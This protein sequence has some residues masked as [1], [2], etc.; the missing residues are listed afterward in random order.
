M[1]SSLRLIALGAGVLGAS[2]CSTLTEPPSPRDRQKVSIATVELPAPGTARMPGREDGWELV[3]SDEFDGTGIDRSKWNF[4]VDCWGGGNDERQCYTDRTENARVADG[5]LIITARKEDYTGPAWPPHMRNG[6]RDPD[7][8]VTKPYTSARL[9][10]RGNAAWT[11]GRIEVRARL[12]QGQG[13]WPAI[14][15]LPEDEDYGTWAASGEIDILEVVN[16][17]IPCAECPSGRE[18]TILGTLHFGGQWPDNAYASTETHA[19]SV[20]DGFHTFGIVWAPGRIDWTYDGQVYATQTKDAWWSSGS[21]AADAPFDRRFHL[22]LNLAVGGKLSE[23]RG[24]K[25]VDES[26][27][28]KTMEVD[29]VRV[30]QCPDA[31]SSADACNG[32]R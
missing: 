13:T 12:P 2:A 32:V 27:Y 19:P 1:I 4:D 18:D 24:L 7:A 8:Q 16:L 29:W 17:G 26:G 11:Y 14:W 15:M 5:R 30:W 6:D 9:V 21:D 23:E 25:G 10:T 31:A 28:P 20:L 22:L 3:W